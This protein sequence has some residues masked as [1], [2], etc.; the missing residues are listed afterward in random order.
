MVRKKKTTNKK[1]SKEY[2]A[3]QF[4]KEHFYFPSL[5]LFVTFLSPFQ[6]KKLKLIGSKVILGNFTIM[7]FFSVKTADITLQKS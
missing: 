6:D 5:L 4:F 3:E 2:R 1:L 7:F